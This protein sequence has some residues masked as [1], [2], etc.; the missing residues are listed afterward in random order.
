ME[1]TDPAQP[2]ILLTDD[3]KM[4]RATARKLLADEFE[5]ILAESGEDAWAAINA[6]P[7]VMAVFTDITMPGLDGFGLLQRI[8]GDERDGINGLPVIMVTGSDEE[9]IREAALDSGATDFISKPFDRAELVARASAYA[10]RDQ[11]RRQAQVLEN[12]RTQDTITGLGNGRYLGSRL[13][14]ARAYSVR[15]E[16]PLALIQVELLDF[17]A[18][19]QAR[20]V[21]AAKRVLREA[22]QVMAR[23]VRAEDVLARVGKAR[24]AALCPNCDG[25][26]A[27]RLAQR[28]IEA[29]RT[30]RFT[31]D[32]IAVGAAAGVHVPA[33]DANEGIQAIYEASQRT[34]KTA[35]G[36]GDGAIVV[37]PT[38]P[39]VEAGVDPEVQR[40]TATETETDPAPA[41]RRAAITLD[42][43]VEIA[44]A[45]EGERRLA[46]DMPELLE[47]C[48]RLFRAAS[49]E[50]AR[51][52]IERLMAEAEQRQ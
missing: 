48:A 41:P 27:Q 39:A 35:V 21:D 1:F 31:T 44:A 9:G 38:A 24:F 37:T 28:L 25:T 30:T 36:R 33:M 14:S 26:G 7:A 22:G 10:T 34:A 46:E 47:R 6:D 40:Q 13:Q 5:L 45:E 2:K 12:S 52:V 8:R 17:D 4:V 29:V 32:A 11:M 23:H 18:M 15:H 50:V 20:G 16:L 19:A 43:A 49:P 42:E 51:P 3:S